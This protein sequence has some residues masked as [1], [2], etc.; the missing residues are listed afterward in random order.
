MICYHGT[1]KEAYA[2]IMKKGVKRH[3]FW[4]PFLSAALTMGGPYVVAVDFPEITDDW[5]GLGNWQYICERQIRPQNFISTLKYHAE[6]LTYNPIADRK[7]RKDWS[8]KDGKKWCRN[9]DGRG[10]TTYL[11]DGHWWLVGG[12]RFDSDIPSR[13]GPLEMCPKCLGKGETK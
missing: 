3:S 8:K 2:L 5:V 10:E 7:M 13:S 12:S 1:D 6:L 9:C 4:T 11:N